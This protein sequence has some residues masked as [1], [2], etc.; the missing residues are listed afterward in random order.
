MSSFYFSRYFRTAYNQT[1]IEYLTEYRIQ[2]A[3]R[4]LEETTIPVREIAFRVGYADAG[5]FSKVF[6]RHVG[7]TPSDYRNR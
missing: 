1:F 3:V 6:K 2:Q 5:Y 7:V 4:L